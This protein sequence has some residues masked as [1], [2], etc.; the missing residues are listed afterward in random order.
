MRRSIWK[1]ETTKTS[2]SSG[3]AYTNATTDR[4]MSRVLS[5]E[6][7]TT[8]NP[9]SNSYMSS[10]QLIETIEDET[11]SKEWAKI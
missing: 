4:R 1:Y 5:K 2:K 6:D 7:V 10:V 9:L 8:A 3:R 11:E